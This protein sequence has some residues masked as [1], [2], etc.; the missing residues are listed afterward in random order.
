MH[1]RCNDLRRR[2]C[3]W[4][5]R[6]RSDLHRGCSDRSIPPTQDDDPPGCVGRA[7]FEP[8]PAGAHEMLQMVL[9][10]AL[11][12]PDEARQR[13]YRRVAGCIIACDIE[14][15]TQQVAV[16]GGQPRVVECRC[17]QWDVGEWIDARGVRT[18]PLS[19]P[20]V[21]GRRGAS[22]CGAV[23]GRSPHSPARIRA[24]NVGAAS[25]RA[26]RSSASRRARS[27]GV[28][29]PRRGGASEEFSVMGS[30]RPLHWFV[31]R[32]EWRIRTPSPGN[33]GWISPRP[34]RLAPRRPRQN[35]NIKRTPEMV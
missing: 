30:D 8:H 15:G 7:G 1:R 21:R 34:D 13:S 2:G 19:G 4:L 14:Q 12:A 32:L 25:A 20:R 33:R 5:H 3:N 9:H 35:R 29:G 10:G 24:W 26:V 11:A 28:S 16:G 31:G 22:G 17:G 23:H 6:G 27:S 18:L